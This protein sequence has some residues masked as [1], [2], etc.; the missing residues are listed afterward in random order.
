MLDVPNIKY[1]KYKTIDSDKI[2]IPL[3]FSDKAIN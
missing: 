1:N 2:D 3:T